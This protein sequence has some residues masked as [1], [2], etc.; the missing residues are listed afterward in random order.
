MTPPLRRIYRLASMSRAAYSDPMSPAL[1]SVLRHTRVVAVVVLTLTALACLAGIAHANMGTA[2]GQDCF[3]PG[4]EQR[5]TCAGPD[6][7]IAP[8]AKPLAAPPVT[9]ASAAIEVLPAQNQRL[10][11]APPL[12][13]PNL[14][15]VCPLAPRSPPAA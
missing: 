2:S 11:V 6:Q 12:V 4:C 1:R 13:A 10:P 5:I 15:A 9:V 14:R 8:T 3:G 7:V